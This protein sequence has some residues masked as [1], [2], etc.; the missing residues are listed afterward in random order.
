MWA[1]VLAAC[2]ALGVGTAAALASPPSPLARQLAMLP[3]I[4]AAARASLGGDPDSMQRRYDAARDLAEST[5]RAVVPKGC[6][7]LQ[8]ALTAF[9]EAEIAVT[10]AYDR[11]RPWRAAQRHAEA[12]RRRVEGIRP[13][14][15]AGGVTAPAD[16]APALSLP[17]AGEVFFGRFAGPAP[18]KSTRVLIDVNGASVATA[19]VRGG[20]FS[21]RATVRSGPALV[22]ALFLNAAGEQVGA[23]VSRDAFA[24]P[25][26]ATKE[27][28]KLRHDRALSARL[29]AAGRAFNGYSSVRLERLGTGPSRS[30]T[31][32]L[33]SLRPRPS[34]SP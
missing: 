14:C 31:V 23:A 4:D 5:R 32:P 19:P 17:G 34:S 25:R 3:R 30:G 10:E 2:I 8:D 12:A 21:V 18:A 33:A 1:R 15:A 16:G 27:P 7:R 6:D 9:A 29:A 11:L 13:R 24:L 20:R 28:A 22:E 26:A